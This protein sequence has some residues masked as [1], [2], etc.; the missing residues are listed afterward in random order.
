[1]VH[2]P[3]ILN[4]VGRESSIAQK[5]NW[6]KNHY[7]RGSLVVQA[8]SLHQG[9]LGYLER[10]LSLTPTASSGSLA[11]L[12]LCLRSPMAL[13][14]R[15]RSRPSSSWNPSHLS[16]RS[17]LSTLFPCCVPLLPHGPHLPCPGAI[18]GPVS[19]F[20]LSVS[21]CRAKSG[22][23]SSKCPQDSG[24]SLVLM[25]VLNRHDDLARGESMTRDQLHVVWECVC[26][27][28]SQVCSLKTGTIWTLCDPTYRWLAGRKGGKKREKRK[29]KYR[30]EG[31][32]GRKEEVAGRKGGRKKR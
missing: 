12:C 16:G 23:D 15:P 25:S 9:D 30:K 27:Q 3:A 4:F 10:E 1:M 29:A 17:C 5:E 22:S 24:Q 28:L 31:K 2:S 6:V 19:L 8:V 26:P 18:S 21:S 13:G 32:E 7:C 11:P 20:L 14:V